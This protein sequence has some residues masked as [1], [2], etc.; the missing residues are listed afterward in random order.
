MVSGSYPEQRTASLIKLL[1][2]P[3]LPSCEHFF[4]SYSSIL[5]ST[6]FKHCLKG[7]RR[8]KARF[9]LRGE[10]HRMPSVKE[11]IESNL[12]DENFQA[13]NNVQVDVAIGRILL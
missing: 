7:K 8:I 9:G 13:E 1:C 11:R 4:S 3:L 5:R 12:G 2:A 10:S 6:C